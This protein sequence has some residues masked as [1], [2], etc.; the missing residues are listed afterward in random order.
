MD[1]DLDEGI[2]MEENYYTF[3]NVPKNVSILVEN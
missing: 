3:L 1:E 2:Q